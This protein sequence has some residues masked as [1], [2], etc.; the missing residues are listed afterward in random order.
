MSFI[1]RGLYGRVRGGFSGLEIGYFGVGIGIGIG[2]MVTIITM[3]M[4]ISFLA[5]SMILC[6]RVRPPWHS[7]SPKSTHSHYPAH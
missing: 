7:P 3:I 4:M 6:V 2:V 1:F 5:R